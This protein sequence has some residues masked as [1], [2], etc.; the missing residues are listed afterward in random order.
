MREFKLLNADGFEWD[1]MR[2]DAFFHAPDGLGFS[3]SVSTVQVGGSFLEISDSLDQKKPSG[4]MVFKG[5][6]QYQEFIS[7]ISKTPL[8]LLYKPLNK[9]YRLQCKVDSLGKT[10]KGINRLICPISFLGLSTWYE[11]LN[12]QQTIPEEGAGKIFPHTYPYKYADTTVA[13]TEIDNG[14]HSSPVIIQIFGPVINPYWT[15]MQQEKVISSGRV[16]VT[17]PGGNKLVINADPAN[18]EIAEYTV[19]DNLFVADHY[20]QSDFST[21]RFI[22]APPGKSVLTIL[23]ESG[24]DISAYVEVEKLADSV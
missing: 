6:E 9:W 17:V 7:F 13:T 19:A 4:E 21:E 23:D 14:N 2:E 11:L 20:P 5:Y 1:L 16:D 18:M 3:R 24:G 10:E 12:A 22:Y 15:L 8:V